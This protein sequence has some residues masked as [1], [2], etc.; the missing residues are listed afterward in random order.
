MRFWNKHRMHTVHVGRLKI[1]GRTENGASRR[2][3][4]NF[5]NKQLLVPD[6]GTNRQLVETRLGVLWRMR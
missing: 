6:R 5:H 2:L 1:R 4:A 3:H